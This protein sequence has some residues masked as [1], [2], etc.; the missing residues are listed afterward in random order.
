MKKTT[1]KL[2]LRSETV[3]ALDKTTLVDVAGGG[4]VLIRCGWSITC[5]AVCAQDPTKT[6]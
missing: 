2:T 6:I 3:R 1:K 4:S 5:P